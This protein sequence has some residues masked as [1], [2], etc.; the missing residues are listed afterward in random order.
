M[1]PTRAKIRTIR[2][3]RSLAL[4]T[5]KCFIPFALW[6]H[7][8]TGGAEVLYQLLL[9]GRKLFYFI[10]RIKMDACAVAVDLLQQPLFCLLLGL[11]TAGGQHQQQCTGE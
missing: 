8:L 4:P 11:G 2:P 5:I 1:T 10:K 7:G 9:G 6:Q 3:V